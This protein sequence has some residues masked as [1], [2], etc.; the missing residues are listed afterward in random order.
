M[1]GEVKIAKVLLG[2]DLFYG[3]AARVFYFV[4]GIYGLAKYRC[5]DLFWTVNIEISTYCNRRCYYCPNAENQTPEEFMSR[6]VFERTIQDLRSIDYRGAITY[7]FYGEP[8]LDSRLVEFVRYTRE[9]LP[10]AMFIKVISNGDYLTIDLFEQLIAA[11]MTEVSIT[12]HDR[13]PGRM[14]AMLAPMIEKHPRNIRVT[15]I[16]G[17]R[18]LSNRGGAVKIVD[19]APKRRCV[20]SRNAVVDRDGNVLLCCNDYFRAHKYGNVMEESIL[21]IWKKADFRKARRTARRGKPVLGICRDCLFP[22]SP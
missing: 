4:Y 14:T 11:G 15:S 13:D 10:K 7:Q 3:I 6:E 21:E 5:Y 1:P 19:E 22:D 18:T 12:I 20:F 2:H 9:N 17:S 16:H 8:L